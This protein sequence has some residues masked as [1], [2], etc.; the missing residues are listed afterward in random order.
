VLGTNDR[1]RAVEKVINAKGLFKDVARS[2]KVLA[3]SGYYADPRGI[4]STGFVD[5][6]SRPRH[7]GLDETPFAYPDPFAGGDSR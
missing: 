6:E 5:F 4:A 3:C 1:R 7:A 2:L